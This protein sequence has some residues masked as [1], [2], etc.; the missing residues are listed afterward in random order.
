MTFQ[1]IENFKV[2]KEHYFFWLAEVNAE[3]RRE[4]MYDLPK[5]N[6]QKSKADY[7]R[8]IEIALSN[9]DVRWLRKFA[10]HLEMWGE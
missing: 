9:N 7:V 3:R 2:T 8:A 1:Y 10:P 5:M 6:N 4:G